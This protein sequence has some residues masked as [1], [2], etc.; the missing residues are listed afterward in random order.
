MTLRLRV[1]VVALLVC[2]S[3]IGPAM[4]QEESPYIGWVSRELTVYARGSDASQVLGRLPAE[5]EVDVYA[6]YRTW[7]Q[8]GF[9]GEKGYVLSKHV[10]R[11]QNRDPFA[12]PMPHVR[13]HAGLALTTRDTQ[14]L[15]EGYQYPI[16]IPKDTPLSIARVKQNRAT[17]PYMRLPEDVSLPLDHLTEVQPFMPW[18]QAQPGDL[19]GAFTT[20]YSTSTKKELNVGRMANIALA[21]DRL[22]DVIIP[23]GGQFSFNAICGPYTQENGYRKAPI[24]SGND[25]VGFGGGTCQVNTTLY[26]VILR[27]P[28]RI[29]EMHWHSQGG[30]KYIA[31]GFDATVGSK[32]D[33]C[34]TNVLPYDL[35]VAFFAQEGVMTAMLYRAAD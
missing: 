32:W 31:S 20:F 27:I 1:S 25:N 23:A 4:A 2:L 19:L 26:N 17:F 12:G 10:E 24:L 11:V 13:L 21:R 8:I 30:V 34:F 29:D 15:P 5:V 9:Q 28:T 7:T 3:L 16:T 22:Q 14:F 33:M 6:K 18:D 35:R